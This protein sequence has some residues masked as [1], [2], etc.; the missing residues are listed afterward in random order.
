MHIR[1]HAG[2][3]ALSGERRCHLRWG[4]PLVPGGELPA[5]LIRSA[6]GRPIVAWPGQAQS[7]PPRT[8]S[9]EGGTHGATR[10][11]GDAPASRTRQA[12]SR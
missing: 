4:T 11:I 10:D 1:T 2:I 6:A 3:I 9:P 7:T 12:S 8:C 5:G